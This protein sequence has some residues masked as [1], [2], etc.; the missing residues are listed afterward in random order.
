MAWHDIIFYELFPQVFNMSITGTLIILAVICVRFLL[1]KAPKLFSYALWAVV[2][3]RLLCPIS[4]SLDV[5]FLNQFD[6]PVT[7]S[8][9]IE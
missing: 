1:K 3:F 8:G 4:F 5:S 6:V 7:E 9:S 2:L